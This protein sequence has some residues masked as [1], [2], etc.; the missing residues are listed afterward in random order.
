MLVVNEQQ[1]RLLKLQYNQANGMISL[2]VPKDFAEDNGWKK[3]DFISFSI[4]NKKVV[5]ERVKIMPG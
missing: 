4:E 3:G 5:L 2:N 1:P